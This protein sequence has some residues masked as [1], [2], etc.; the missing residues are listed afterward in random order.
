MSPRANKIAAFL[1]QHGLGQPGS[2]KDTAALQ[3]QNCESADLFC[4]LFIPFFP[5]PDCL[6]GLVVKASASRAEGP[7]FESPLCRDFFGVE[8]YQ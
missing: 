1:P 4:L 3:T 7:G 6:I 5:L 8:S 2:Q